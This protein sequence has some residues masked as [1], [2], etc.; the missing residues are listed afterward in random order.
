[1]FIEADRR[2]PDLP[3][4]IGHD[5]GEGGLRLAKQTSN[6]YLEFSGSY[7]E[8]D[9]IRKAIDQIGANRVVF[10]TDFDMTTPAFALGIYHEADM[11][12]AE[13]RL[14]MAENSRRILGLF[15]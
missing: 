9:V 3:I 7:P 11:T 4:I 1:M 6:I 12:S 14:V 13:E 5:M 15:R 8:R 2:H 10:G